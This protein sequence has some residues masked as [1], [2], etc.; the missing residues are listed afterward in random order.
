MN[1]TILEDRKVN[2]GKGGEIKKERKREKK[3]EK[4]S[5]RLKEKF[6][7]ALTRPRFV[8]T[9][10]LRLQ[11]NIGEGVPK[12]CYQSSCGGLLCRRFFKRE[13]DAPVRERVREG[14]ASL[15]LPSVRSLSLFLSFAYMFST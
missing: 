11:G 13:E 4:R 12:A 6:P 10:Y 2:D 8:M 5:G 1:E 15:F 7:V 3:S 14:V 9:I